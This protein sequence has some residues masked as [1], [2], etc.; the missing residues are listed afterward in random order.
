VQIKIIGCS[1]SFPG[2]DSAASSYLVEADGF[3]LLM[4]LGA[5]A[6][7]A[8]QQYA[9]LYA[10]DA[11]CISHLH[12]DHCLDLCSYSVARLYHP[13]G[14]KLRIPVYGPSQTEA[15]LGQALA[16]D[17]AQAATNP[18]H[19]MTDAFSFTAITPGTMEIGPLRITAARMS[20]PV[21]TY[22]FRIEHA[23]RA[24]TY[25]ADTGPSD[26]L[27]DLAR[28]AD[29]LLCEASFL[30]PA[31]GGAAGL[32][33]G[34]HLTARQAAQHAERAGAGELVLT[35]LV[36]WNDQDRTLDEARGAFSGESYLAA[37]GLS[38]VLE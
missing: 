13:D 23:G 2:P 5:G 33:P 31:D 37:P 8:L 15:R 29:F 35:H 18:G 25:S 36:P 16:A 19:G 17:P 34:L 12:G 4:D 6:L 27:V 11:V 38:L 24:L 20:H 7:G 10:I 22:G 30:E 28:D 32:P 1:G 21:E 3:R 9:D 14:P 26:A